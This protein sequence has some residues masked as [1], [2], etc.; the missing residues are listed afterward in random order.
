M[1][2]FLAMIALVCAAGGGMALGAYGLG[3]SS[4]LWQDEAKPVMSLHEVGRIVR[5]LRA[6]P[7]LLHQG[8]PGAINNTGS[9][10][11]YTGDDS[12]QWANDGECDDPGLGTGAC[13]QGTDYS[14]CWRLATNVEDDSCQWANDGECDEPHFGTGACTQATDLTDCGP[15]SYLRNQNDSCESAF[16]G[17]CDEPGTGS[18][19]CEA[20]TDRADCM[21]RDRP[22]QISDHYF[23]H[24]DRVFMDTSQMPWLVVGTLVDDNGGSC[25][26]TLIGEDILITAAHCIEY[27][28]GIDATGTFNTGFGRRGGPLT[29]RV[30]DFLVSPERQTER[31]TSD[32]PSNTDWA[33]IRID[34]PLGRELGFLGVRPLRNGNPQAAIGTPLLQA[35]YS[36]DTGD[37]LSGNL[38]CEVIDVED[39][40]KL[41]HN[42]DTTT[43]DSGSPFL[44]RDGNDYFVV[45]VDSTFRFAP[46]T[47]AVN[48]ATG[49]NGFLPYLED[50]RNGVI[51]NGGVR[52]QTPTSGKVPPKE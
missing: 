22:M 32:E 29:A 15:V 37:H 9:S 19:A 49:S 8:K 25:T 39:E 48:I 34:Q 46:N 26:A 17:A 36:W 35:G 30:T 12:C 16:N 52:P 45:G 13:T 11:N 1:K 4:P 3:P 27:E 28:S 18:G 43:G 5:A 38:D 24:D 31:T 44:V 6:T 23:G 42:C 20:G 21:G 40:N 2:R 51:G 33:L 47:P 14:D 7:G 41:A 10:G 50:F